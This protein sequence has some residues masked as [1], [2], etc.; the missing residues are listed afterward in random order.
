M[1]RKLL[2]IAK[3]L[4]K[5]PK[6]SGGRGTALGALLGAMIIQLIDNGI[7]ILKKVDLGAFTLSL[8]KEYSKIIIGIAII[9]AV[10]VD[11]LSEYLR[12]RRQR[13]RGAG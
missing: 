9:L 5:R 12:N 4:S 1:V 3:M 11:R 2:L 10:T 7:F 13:G 6:T 8:S